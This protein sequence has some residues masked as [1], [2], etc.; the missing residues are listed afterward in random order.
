MPA[1]LPFLPAIVGL[2]GAGVSLWQ[3]NQADQRNQ[4]ANAQANAAT[5]QQQALIQQLMSGLNPQAYQQQAAQAGNQ[6]LSQL[7]ANFGQRGALSSGA[8]QQAGATTLGQLYSDAQARYQQDQQNA[9][10]MALGG[11]QAIQRQYAGQVNPDPYAGLGTALGAL[12][13]AAGGYL[14][15]KY[16][17]PTTA[18]GG[19]TGAGLPGFG[20][21]YGR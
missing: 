7:A 16:G 20:V 4:Q 9:I 17:Q 14:Q 13:T 18:Y 15:Q 2:A 12:G 10:G 6:A 19:S 1:I 21:R 3:G 11:Q 8:F 5:A